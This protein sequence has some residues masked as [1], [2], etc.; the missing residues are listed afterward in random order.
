[1]IKVC[2]LKD[3][4]GV[5]LSLVRL[6]L[7]QIMFFIRYLAAVCYDIIILFVLFFSL[8]ALVVLVNKG[9]A[10]P[11]STLWYQL[12]LSGIGL[13]YY[14]S[15]IRFGGQTLGMR[16]WRFKLMTVDQKRLTN[17]DIF[18]RIVCFIPALLLAPVYMKSSYSVLNRWTNTSFSQ[19]E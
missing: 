12:L 9:H 6:R 17:Q 15:S 1:M 7:R 10:I 19:V 3:I 16:A 8:T 2:G 14:Q 4:L 13:L 5:F 18:L 11:P